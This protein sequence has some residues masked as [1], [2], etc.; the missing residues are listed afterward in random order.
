MKSANITKKLEKEGYKIFYKKWGYW[1]NIPHVQLEGFEFAI[2]EYIYLENGW[3]GINLDFIY[4]HVQD[5]LQ[6]AQTNNPII[7]KKI[8]ESPTEDYYYLQY[9][10]TNMEDYY[11]Y[12]KK[13]YPF[14]NYW[15][16]LQKLE[17]ES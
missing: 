4:N 8:K 6:L 12:R 5:A 9:M 10:I 17:K 16:V 1:D 15:T 11:R 14:D 3:R 7:L 13:K 2:A